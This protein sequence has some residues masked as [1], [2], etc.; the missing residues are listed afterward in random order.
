[1][2]RDAEPRSTR[3]LKRLGEI[4]RRRSEGGEWNGAGA[5]SGAG[6]PAAEPTGSTLAPTR[7]PVGVEEILPGGE[8]ESPFGRVF[9]HERL[10]SAVE[11]SPGRWAKPKRGQRAKVRV[12]PRWMWEADPDPWRWDLDPETGRPAPPMCDEP[13]ET[14][15]PEV[16]HEELE[17]LLRVPFERVLY[18][19]LETGGLGSSCIFLAGTMR[20][21][22]EDYVLRQYFARHY[23]EEAA[24]I[25]RLADDLATADAVVTFNGKSF[26]VPLLRDRA[27]RHLIPLSL[28]GVHA[29]LLHHS[30]AA[31]RGKVPNCRLTT[32]EAYVC[33]RR[34]SGDVPGDEVPGL[35]HGFVRDGG[36]ERLIPVFHH[37]LLDVITM[38][39]LLRRLI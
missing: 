28:P 13:P 37:N 5:W 17:R 20:W 1:M 21:V 36:G 38:D 32:L 30:R 31:W 8:L 39:E 11:R 2:I 26:D 33:Q 19:D 24:L 9:L 14:L 35:Y 25:E 18:L 34:R 10:R 3:L 4:A 23:G 12:G 16:L 15:A 27:A 6:E 22:G 7:I 29:D